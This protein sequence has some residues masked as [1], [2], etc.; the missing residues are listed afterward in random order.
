MTPTYPCFA[1]FLQGVKSIAIL[2]QFGSEVLYTLESLVLLRFHGFLLGKF[3]VLV[4]NSGE[5]SE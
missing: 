1:L 4:Y 2:R 3:V 5:G